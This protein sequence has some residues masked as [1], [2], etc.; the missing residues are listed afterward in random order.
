MATGKADPGWLIAGPLYFVLATTTILLTRNEHHFATV[1]PA[2][3]ALVALLLAQKKPQWTGALASGFVANVL[4][5]LVVGNSLTSPLLYGFANFTEI[6]VV[7]SL[8]RQTQSQSR[9]L[10][11][12]ANVLRFVAIAGIVGPLIGAL[13]G[14]MTSHFAFGENFRQAVID[15]A[16]SDS[17]GLLVF[18]PFF[19]ALFTG[20]YMRLITSQT[21]KER[22]EMGLL[23]GLVAA[24]TWFV[25]FAAARPLLFMLFAPM[26]LVTFRAGRLGTKLGII[27]I[28]TIGTIATLRNTGP[29]A[30]I[31]QDTVEQAHLF[32]GFL[33]VLVLTCLPVAADLSARG[34]LTLKLVYRE[35]ELVV[36]AT[37]DGLTGLLNRP[38]FI[39]RA[40]ELLSTRSAP[41]SLVAI[42]LDHF[43]RVNDTLGH[44]A[45]D[46]ALVHLS[47]ILR[48]HLRGNETGGRLGGDEFLLLLPRCDLDE[49]AELCERIRD[50]LGHAPLLIEGNAPLW[51]SMSCGV[52]TASNGETFEALALRADQALYRAK[53]AGRNKVVGAA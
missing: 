52:V 51:L 31:A 41:L 17:L 44:H 35:R 25:F 26:M 20:E 14:G 1:W 2:N 23:L 43:K 3:A 27:L 24:S 15:W 38:A 39:D 49:A 37:T 32:Q 45:G 6:I 11:S 47:A 33:A 16:L 22:I 40:V 30:L 42:D 34:D 19:Y 4:A 9:I 8:L 53:S 18:T 28:A 5:N 21:T 10:G 46:R 12:A 29:I 50:N 7:S 36:Q 48:S 13:V